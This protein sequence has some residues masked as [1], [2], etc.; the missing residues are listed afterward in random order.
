MLGILEI[1][2]DIIHD[3]RLL[4]ELSK[5]DFSK[6]FS[7]TYFGMVWAFVQPLLLILVYLF[8]FQFGFRS[9]DV[10]GYSYSVWFISGIVPWLFFNE[11]M[12][13]ASN[14]F[15]EYDYLIKKVKFNIT[16][17]PVVKIL[18]SFFI[19]LF[20][21]ALVL[22][23]TI[24]L[25][26]SMK[27]KY[28]Q[29]IYYMIAEILLLFSITLVTSTIVVYFRDL[30]QIINVLLLLG[31]WGTPIAWNADGFSNKTKVLFKLN[32][33]YYVIEGYRD[34]VM[35]RTWFWEKPVQTLYFWGMVVCFAM[36]GGFVFSRMRDYFAET[37]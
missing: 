9:G 22:I 27:F 26:Y 32:P 5:K 12:V 10:D 33:I 1:E 2:K 24:G 6:R 11:A 8:A 15:V 30:N 14:S 20:F 37:V 34:S 28:I 21:N 18:S 31:M 35:G 25:G 4:F 23:I 16:I 13:T 19:H 3:R 7:G 17:L 36:L 29:L